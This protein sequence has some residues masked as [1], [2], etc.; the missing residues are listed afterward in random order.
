M[1]LLVDYIDF[2][3]TINIARNMNEIYDKSVIFHCFWHGD[4]NE[5]HL[6]SIKSCYYFNVYKKKHKIILW[7]EK[8]IPNKYLFEIQNYAEIKFFFQEFEKSKI[9]L[10]DYNPFFIYKPYYSDFVRSLLLYNYGGCWFD[11]DCFFLRSF[12]PLF[13][14]YDKE[15]CLYT[16]GNI[17]I[18]N[19]AIYISLIPKSVKMGRNMEFIINY[20]KGWGFK[21]A[22]LTF[23]LNIDMLILPCS[24]FDPLFIRECPDIFEHT[25]NKYNFDNFF[26][27]CFCYHWHNQWDRKIEENSIISQLIKIIDNNLLLNN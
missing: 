10:D 21:Q 15:I 11:L 7:L 20:N 26:N 2:D 9:G 12:D 16:W 17:N 1:K 24:W 23:D 8:T 18:P 19:N 6:Y 22:N 3:K 13:Y 14:H 5:K 27:G 25:D 4:L